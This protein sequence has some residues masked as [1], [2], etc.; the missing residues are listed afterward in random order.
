[1]SLFARRSVSV[2]DAH[3]AAGRG[4]LLVD[5]RTADEWTRQGRA[6]GASHIPLAS[7]PQKLERLRGREVLVICRSGRRSATAAALLRRNGISALN[8]RGGMIAWRRHDLPL[9]GSR[10][11]GRRT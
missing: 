5:V 4:A 9:D 11:K 8:V 6:A 2:V 7:L 3:Q 1:V 10:G